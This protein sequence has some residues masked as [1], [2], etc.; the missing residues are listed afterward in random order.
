VT[1]DTQADKAEHDEHANHFEKFAIT[2]PEH[3]ARKVVKGILSNK[4]Q[5]CTSADSKFA[6]VMSRLSPMGGHKLMAY[7]MRKVANPK[8]YR[9]LDELAK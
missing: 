4:K 1:S 9:R 7:V 3:V 5:V 6:Q 2:T 8:L